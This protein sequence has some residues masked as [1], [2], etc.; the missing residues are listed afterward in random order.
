[1]LLMPPRS[2]YRTRTAALLVLDVCDE[3]C[4]RLHNYYQLLQTQLPLSHDDSPVGPGRLVWDTLSTL[5]GP[6]D[7]GN[8]WSSHCGEPP[9]VCKMF[10]GSSTR[11]WSSIRVPLYIFVM[12]WF[13]LLFVII[14]SFFWVYLFAWFW[15]YLF[16]LLLFCFGSAVAYFGVWRTFI[17]D[18]NTQ[19]GPFMI[20]SS[21]ISLLNKLRCSNS[22]IYGSFYC[23]W[24][25]ICL[26]IY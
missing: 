16:D 14:F 8:L 24:C 19:Y 2:C 3:S 10:I 1:M 26:C 12:L 13:I 6:L 22:F 21:S 18:L 5:Y 17:H 20:D 9:W 25:V 4:S 7:F 23:W 15:V 11:L